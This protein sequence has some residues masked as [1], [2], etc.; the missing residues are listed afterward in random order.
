MQ[1]FVILC[2]LF[3]CFVG[4]KAYWE[5][6]TDWSHRRGVMHETIQATL[7]LAIKHN[8]IPKSA[9]KICPYRRGCEF[10][11]LSQIKIWDYKGKEIELLKV[12]NAIIR[13]G[14]GKDV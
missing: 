9:C 6:H 3:M 13:D 8:E 12:I 1:T 4:Y 5:L 2:I 10:C 7:M 14:E 11:Q